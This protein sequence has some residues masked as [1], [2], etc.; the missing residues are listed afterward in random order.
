MYSTGMNRVWSENLRRSP[1]MAL[2]SRYRSNSPA[3]TWEMNARTS[4]I[5]WSTFWRG[6]SELF[7]HY[8]ILMRADWFIWNFHMHFFFV[9]FFCC[10][11]CLI[12]GGKKKGQLRSLGTAISKSVEIK[13]KSIKFRLE[14]HSAWPSLASC[15]CSDFRFN[16]PI[17]SS[18]R[19]NLDIFFTTWS[20]ELCW[21]NSFKWDAFK[22]KWL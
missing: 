11:V 10:G 18:K 12:A 22:F 13:E 4:C 8:R 19:K 20:K 9:F 6:L 2:A 7:I 1:E 21:R 3:S 17:E 15:H 14:L 16:Q 5:V